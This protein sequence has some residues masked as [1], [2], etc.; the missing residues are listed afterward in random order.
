[1]QG[2][3]RSSRL[4][5][6]RTTI[7]SD[8]RHSDAL[9]SALGRL[10]VAVMVVDERNLLRALN[11]RAEGMVVSEG[12][13]ADLLTSRP[14]HPLS[15]FIEAILGRGEVP[16]SAVLAFPTGSRYTIEASRR[17]EKN[18]NRWIVLLFSEAPPA[19]TIDAVLDSWALTQ[20]EREVAEL[21]IE[22]ISSAQICARIAIA[23]NTLKSHVKAILDKS[24]AENRTALLAKLLRER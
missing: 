13:A 8:A 14:S 24:G 16:E 23:E 4:A 3:A 17:S 6:N 1:M 5:Y 19:R 10:P 12:L 11:V 2:V 22:G 9:L 18:A 21:M 20:R 7:M 15:R